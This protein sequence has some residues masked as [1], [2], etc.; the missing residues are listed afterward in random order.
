MMI[1]LSPRESGGQNIRATSEFDYMIDSKLMSALR[2]RNQ[3]K[4]TVV[5]RK[6]GRKISLPVWFVLEGDSLML[7]PVNG[8]ETNWFRN[9]K[10]TPTIKISVGEESITAKP[11]LS[12]KPSEVHGIA[13]KIRA[14]YEV[15]DMKEYYPK[16]NALVKVPLV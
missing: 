11:S 10:K 3:I 14:K 5:G 9:L 8:D 1:I 4:I 7:L 13:E 15:R 2:S 16:L 6:T 12:S